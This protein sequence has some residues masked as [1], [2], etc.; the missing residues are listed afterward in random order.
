[1]F[2]AKMPRE[3][4]TNEQARAG[5]PMDALQVRHVIDEMEKHTRSKSARAS[6]AKL[7]IRFGNITPEGK[8]VYREYL[9]TLS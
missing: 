6:L 7:A 8:E 1:M 2:A 5:I 9:I 4:R 3:I